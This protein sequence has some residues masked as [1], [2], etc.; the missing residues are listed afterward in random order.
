MKFS[1]QFPW[2]FLFKFPKVFVYTRFAIRKRKE[3]WHL[4]NLLKWHVIKCVFPTLLVALQFGYIHWAGFCYSCNFNTQ[5]IQW[6][7]LFTF[8]CDIHVVFLSHDSIVQ[9]NE[10]CI[11]WYRSGIGLWNGKRDL[12]KKIKRYF[13]LFN[14]T[15]HLSCLKPVAWSPFVDDGIMFTINCFQILSLHLQLLQW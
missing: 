2:I 4:H 15:N 8:Y 12:I 7:N 6:K 5:R 3:V 11:V 9:F 1:F 13:I 14:D 10:H